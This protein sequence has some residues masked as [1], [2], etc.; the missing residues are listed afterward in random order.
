MSY[1][2]ERLREELHKEIGEAIANEMRDPRVPDIVT[3]TEVNLAPDC[4][5]ATIFVSLMGDEKEKTEALSTLNKAAP[6]LQH[7]VAKRIVV[8]FIPKLYFK[9][10]KT[11]EQSNRLNDLFNTIR[12]DLG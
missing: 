10:D 3:V 6:F 9:I 2:R 7:I 4:R 12:S 5:N 8:K 1:H 11:I